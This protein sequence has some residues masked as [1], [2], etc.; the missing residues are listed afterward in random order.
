MGL[1][2]FS[3]GG[4]CAANLALR[5][6]PAGSALGGNP[7]LEAANS[8]LTIAFPLNAWPPLIYL[9]PIQEPRAAGTSEC[10]AGSSHPKTATPPT[11]PHPP[12]AACKV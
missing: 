1:L 3:S 4:Y 5:D 7:A 9:P 2:G 6:G 11:S 10:P 12:S 8:P